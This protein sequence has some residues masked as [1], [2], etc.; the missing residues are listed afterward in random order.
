MHSGLLPTTQDLRAVAVEEVGLVGGS[1]LDC[2]EDGDRLFLRTILPMVR[3]VRPRDTVQGGVALM[4]IGEEIRVHP[5]TFRQVCRNGAIMAEAIQTRRV[6]RVQF[7]APG[8]R[9]RGGAGRV[10]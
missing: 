8:R 9:G 10:A 5:Y 1:E 2:F 3:H 7:S 6:Q 4:T